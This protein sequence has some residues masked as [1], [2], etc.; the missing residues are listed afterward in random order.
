M[1]FRMVSFMTS[2]L[3]NGGDDRAVNNVLTWW[4]IAHPV[5]Y[6]TNPVNQTCSLPDYPVNDCTQINWTR[7]KISS[8]PYETVDST[9][10]KEMMHTL[11]ILHILNILYFVFCQGILICSLYFKYRLKEEEKILQLCCTKMYKNVKC[12]ARGNFSKC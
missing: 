11:I 2:Y 10:Y 3:H 4:T 1:I 9:V 12:L 5:N 8:E 7:Q 6:V